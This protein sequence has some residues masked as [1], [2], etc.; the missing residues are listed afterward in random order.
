MIL[1]GDAVLHPRFQGAQQIVIF[2]DH[3]SVGAVAEGIRSFAAAAM[4]HA[5]HHEDAVEVAQLLIALV[6]AVAPLAA[7]D[8]AHSLVV[9]DAVHRRDGRPSRHTGSAFL[10]APRTAAGPGSSSSPRG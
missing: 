1:R 7:K 2:V 4:S 9:V 6:V 5:G 10:R 3:R 8:V